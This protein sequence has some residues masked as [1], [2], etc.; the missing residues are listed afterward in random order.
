MH[1][2]QTVE[3]DFGPFVNLFIK[4]QGW[5]MDDLDS[6]EQTTGL[7]FFFHP[8]THTHT[9]FRGLLRLRLE[10]NSSLTGDPTT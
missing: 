6:M 8:H 3:L 9:K 10:G 7:F 2:S 1:K 4:T 5:G